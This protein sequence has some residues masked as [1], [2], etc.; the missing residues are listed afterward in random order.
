MVMRVCDME[1]DQGKQGGSL[2]FHRKMVREQRELLE[3]QGVSVLWRVPGE[4]TS[5]CFL[6]AS[7]G[8]CLATFFG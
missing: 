3:F 8:V 6:G 5:L 7:P 4:G 2:I 1:I